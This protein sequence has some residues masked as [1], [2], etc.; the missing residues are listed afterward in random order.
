M[1]SIA[2]PTDLNTWFELNLGKSF[3]LVLAGKVFGGRYGES[4]Q[5]LKGA[6]LEGEKLQLQFNKTETMTILEP[7]YV[8]F[9]ENGLCIERAKIV[10]F[11]WHSHGTEEEPQNWRTIRYQDKGAQILIERTSASPVHTEILSSL[12]KYAVQLVRSDA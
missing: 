1:Q 9:E 12:P 4:P 8:S 7:R 3:D 6:T 11:G 5:K 2:L 10:E